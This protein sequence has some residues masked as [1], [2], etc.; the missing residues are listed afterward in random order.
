MSDY[1]SE[2]LFK[3]SPSGALRQWRSWSQGNTVFTEH[4]QVGGKLQT[5]EDA[6]KGKS[7]GRS[8]ET[9]PEQQAAVEAKQLRDAYV[10]KGYVPDRTRAEVVQNSLPA[11]LPMLAHVYEDA[12]EVKYPAHAQPKLD[13]VRCLALV[14]RGK[15]LLYTRSQKVVDTVPHIVEAVEKWARNRSIDSCS[16]DGELYNHALK[17]DFGR[18]LG[19]VKR[20]GVGEDSELVHYYIYDFPSQ[21]PFFIRTKKLLTLFSN[22]TRP[23]VFVETVR[24]NNEEDLRE[25]AGDWVSK[26]YEG[27]MYRSSEGPYEGKRSRHLLKVK[28]MKDDDF[29]VTGYQEG[30]GKL[31]GL[32]GAWV[33]RMK[34]GVE[35]RAKM[36]GKL[37]DLSKF[38]SAEAKSKIGK[39]LRVRY[40]GLTPD[41]VP[42]FPVGE[43][44]RDGVEK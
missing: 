2:V 15:C 4:G 9:T 8:N 43:R 14:R 3:T 26:G 19:A 36:E 22:V 16:L 13:G 20:K 32:V 37:E 29:E 12:R 23:L 10:K 39:I 30:R 38:D 18:I 41:G 34:S 7:L 40:Q 5:S 17:D 24:V 31:M 42:R 21:D 27:A 33:C 35:F 25:R 1:R 28:T 44:F 6:V 11:F